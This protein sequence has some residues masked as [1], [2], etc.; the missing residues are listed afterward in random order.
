MKDKELLE[1]LRE[2]FYQIT[3]TVDKI[4]ERKIELTL[5]VGT[6][7]KTVNFPDTQVF[8][9]TVKGKKQVIEKS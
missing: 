9:V 2:Q 3:Q 5:G 7:K 4:V 8:E 1:K 6:N